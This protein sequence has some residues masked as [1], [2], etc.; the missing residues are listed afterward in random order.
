MKT[1]IMS[2]DRYARIY[3]NRGHSPL[4]VSC[5]NKIHINEP[6]E[7]IKGSHRTK[8]LCENC[9]DKPIVVYQYPSSR[10][11]HNQIK[12]KKWR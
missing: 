5:G 4:C 6:I 7:N 12:T 11:E 9:K 8:Y 3:K 1:G 10:K 2:Q